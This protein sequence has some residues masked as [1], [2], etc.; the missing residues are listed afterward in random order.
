M[1]MDALAGNVAVVTGAS[2]GIGRAIALA[3]AQHGATLC[4]VGRHRDTLTAVA[5][6]TPEPVSRSIH[7]FEA[8]LG[9]DETVRTL[10]HAI[11]QQ[12]QHVDILVHCGGVYGRGALRDASIDQLDLLYRVNVRGPYLLTQLLLTSLTR[13]RGQIVF[14]NSTQGLNAGAN[15]G[16][17]AATQHALKAIAD[18]LRQELN[19]DGVRVLSIYPG[20]TATPRTES[21]HKIENK[22]YQPELLLQ[23]HDIAAVVLNALELPRT[24]EITNIT[25]RPL[26]KSY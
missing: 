4:L 18:S 13:R 5:A 19:P 15:V 12:F 2:S 3:L 7:V 20:R 25:I 8:D 16:Q 1:S 26:Q 14:V 11:G 21:V 23:P 24:A 22:T 6:A 17:F 10:A 9:E